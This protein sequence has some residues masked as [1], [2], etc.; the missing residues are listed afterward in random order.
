M[1]IEEQVATLMQGT[2]YGDVELKNAM[3]KE[4]H[5]RLIQAQVE[6]R[7]LRVYAGFDPRTTDLH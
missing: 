5:E 2:E 3:Q 4:L 6:K 1:N 7:P